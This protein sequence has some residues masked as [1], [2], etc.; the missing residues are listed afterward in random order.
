MSGVT[1]FDTEPTPL[2]PAPNET[3]INGLPADT[4]ALMIERKIDALFDAQREAL[5]QLAETVATSN[6]E[7][8]DGFRRILETMKSIERHETMLREDRLDIN[9]L[10]GKFNALRDRVDKLERVAAP[11]KRHKA[12]K[13]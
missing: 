13:R 6:K 4:W 12:G 10:D 11:K 2:P 8:S 9:T 1:D 7:V 5:Q 3:R